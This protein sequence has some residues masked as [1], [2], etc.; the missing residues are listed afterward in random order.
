MFEIL[1][2]KFKE[3]AESIFAD[4]KR[5]KILIILSLLARLLL[6][7]TDGHNSDFDFF[8]NWADRIV[9]FGFQNIYSIQVDRFECDYPPL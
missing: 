7:L 5:W 1:N 4:Q 9:Q 8:E 3:Y 2:T 6:F